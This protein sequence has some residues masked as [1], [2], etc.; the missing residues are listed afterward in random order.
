MAKFTVKK[1]NSNVIVTMRI[2]GGEWTS[3]LETGKKSAIEDLEI[4]GFRK[5]HVPANIAEKY[6][7]EG[8]IREEATNNIINKEWSSAMK[9]MKDHDIIS[10]PSVDL[11]K[12]SN[13]E[14]EVTFT[15]ALMPEVILG[16]T[17]GFEAKVEV[18]DVSEEEIE[19]ELEQIKTLLIKQEEI[20]EK[21]D[22]GHIVNIDFLGKKEGKPFDG[23]EA[24]GFDLKIGSGQ[25]IEGFEEKMKGMK[26]GEEKVIELSFPKEYPSPDLAGA[27]VTFDV[28]IN[29]IKLEK[30]LKGEEL[31]EKLKTMGFKSM[32]DVIEKVTAMI[33][34][35]KNQQSQDKF[36]EAAV[37][38]IIKH[39]DTKMTLPE[40]IVVDALNKKMEQFSQS[41]IQQG[42]KLEQYL[43]MIGKTKEEFMESDMRPQAKQ[44]VKQQLI[45]QELLKIFTKVEATEEQVNNEIKK[46]ADAQGMKVEDVKKAIPSSNIKSSI[47]FNNLVF[48]MTK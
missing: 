12:V 46:I 32:E 13:T 37:K 3:A 1:E 42:M 27:E 19:K 5:G 10:Q 7:S 30:K 35:R 44:D 9:E 36:F 15:S 43:E 34:E 38:E 21:I 26:L 40:S 22:E 4:K 6:I 33:K 20:K 14:L 11:V 18:E 23:G 2:T 29:S 48:E 45:Y 47:T 39:K 25:F 8:K 24:K 31:N 41:I 16:K 28:K 17:T